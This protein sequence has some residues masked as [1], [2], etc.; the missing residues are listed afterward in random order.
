MD[1]GEK[2]NPIGAASFGLVLFLALVFLTKWKR[3]REAVVR[4][5]RGLNSYVSEQNI[6]QEPEFAAEQ[7][8]SS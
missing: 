6:E 8:P 1:S 7:Q 4:L 2:M 5:N 3:R